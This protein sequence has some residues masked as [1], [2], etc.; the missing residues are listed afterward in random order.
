MTEHRFRLSQYL[1]QRL[2]IVTTQTAATT[3]VTQ[4]AVGKYGAGYT[5][6][7]TNTIVTNAIIANKSSTSQTYTICL[8]TVCIAYQQNIAANATV[9]IDLKQALTTG[10]LVMGSASS[11]LVNLHISGM[12]VN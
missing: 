11:P 12:T 6:S 9:A 8:D 5:T 3:A 10:K 1:R 2:Y 7:S 4:G